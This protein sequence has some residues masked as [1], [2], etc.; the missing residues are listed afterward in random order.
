M[1]AGGEPGTAMERATTAVKPSNATAS[2]PRP[3]PPRE[4]P[5]VRVLVG[6]SPGME[7]VSLDHPQHFL[8]LA[9]RGTGRSATVS[10]PLTV[11]L[12]AGEWVA[13]EERRPNGGGDGRI[14][15]P[16]DR[17]LEVHP[18]A[19]AKPVVVW[20]RTSFP[21]S[22][23]LHEDQGRVEVVVHVGLESYLPG[24]L[25]KELFPGWHAEAYRAQAVAARSY[26]LVEM[27]RWHDRRHYDMVAGERN[28]AWI[29]ETTRP[30]ALSGVKSTEGQVLTFD[31]AVVPGYY[32]SCCGGV[33][34]N[35]GDSVNSN[36]FHDI[37]PLQSGNHGPRTGAA[38]C[39]S[40]SVR[41]WSVEL[42]ETD[43]RNRLRE[44]GRERKRPDIVA[45]GRIIVIERSREN[46]SGRAVQY[47]IED[48]GGVRFTIDAEEFR[49][50]LNAY[51]P[52]G[53]RSIRSGDFLAGRT[54]GG[55]W[56]LEGR[57]FGHGCGLCQYGA[58]GMA[59][60]GATASHILQRY[61][62]GASLTEAW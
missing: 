9:Q 31:G 28:Q 37:A 25:A 7:G 12:Q 20:G 30:Q 16:A 19:D 48:A 50:A 46:A 3:V 51:G 1:L 44:W 47:T 40:A 53:G 32:S 24:V 5:T 39:E 23:V 36:P 57:G 18:L 42:G 4:E 52:S 61:Y 14:V 38:C 15:F 8:W 27:D 34:A 29:G 43:M 56:R 60:E 62:P 55:S 41:T 11:R 58:Q 17:P 49:R 26:S 54:R 35:V 22:L 33:G 2:R 13:T 45:L 10:S 21:G 59:M 6:V